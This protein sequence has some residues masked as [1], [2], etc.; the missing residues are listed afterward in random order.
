MKRLNAFLFTIFSLAYFSVLFSSVDLLRQDYM[1]VI[2]LTLTAWA[3][4]NTF[5]DMMDEVFGK[6]R[7][8]I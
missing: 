7:W 3:C 6:E 5:N 4:G 2:F 1:F 8:R